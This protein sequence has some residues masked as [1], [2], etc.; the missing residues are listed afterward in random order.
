MV[1]KGFEQC[2]GRNGLAILFSLHGAENLLKRS[3]ASKEEFTQW[4]YRFSFSRAPNKE[5]LAI[6]NELLGNEL[7]ARGIEDL[8]WVVILQ[9]E[10]QLVR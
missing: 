2:V 8:L 6:A 3:W 4:L 10:F 5:E 1:F 7:S 9:P